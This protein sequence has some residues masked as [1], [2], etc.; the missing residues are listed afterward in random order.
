MIHFISGHRDVTE[1]EFEKYYIP[2]INEAIREGDT[3]VVGDY[4]GVDQMAMNY[5]MERGAEFKI[6]HMFDKPRHTPFGHSINFCISGD[7][8]ISFRGG[9]TSDEARDSAMT[10][11]SHYDIA[12]VRPGKWDSGTAE[13]IYRRH[14]ML[15]V[16][17]N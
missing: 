4:E 10:E 8:D 7:F 11:I 9:F 1:E 17:K 12:F 6:F 3:F 13:N 14:E 5:L 2:K 16:L 15:T